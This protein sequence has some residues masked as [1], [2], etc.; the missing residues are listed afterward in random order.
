M[1]KNQVHL[2]HDCIATSKKNL[3]KLEKEYR[4]CIE[5]KW[6]Q[7]WDRSYVLCTNEK[8]MAYRNL[9]SNPYIVVQWC[10]DTISE[11]TSAVVMLSLHHCTTI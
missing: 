3:R 9:S 8:G 10:S 6:R 1:H 5:R 11:I 7:D 4:D 2:D